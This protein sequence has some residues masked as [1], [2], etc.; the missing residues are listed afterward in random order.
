MLAIAVLGSAAN[1]QSQDQTNKRTAKA[2]QDANNLT[3]NDLARQQDQ[4]YSAA[5]AQMNDAAKRALHD[6]AL[7]DTVA[8]EYGGGKSVDRISNVGTVNAGETLATIASNASTA[9]SETAFRGLSATAMANSRLA[10]M[11]QPSMLGTALQIGG[12][13]LGTY[14]NYQQRNRS[15]H[16]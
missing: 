9:A 1:Y 12:A 11:Q 2:Q 15:P 13:A 3:Q 7:F 8:G 14:G 4:Q 6:Q 5:S 10:S 16:Q